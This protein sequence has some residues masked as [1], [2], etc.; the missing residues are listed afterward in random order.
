[1]SQHTYDMYPYGQATNPADTAPLTL[2]ATREEAAAKGWDLDD[3]DWA[4]AGHVAVVTRIEHEEATRPLRM[5]VA[6]NVG[7]VSLSHS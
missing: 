2:R 7:N 6:Q 1:M 3:T 4:D 5:Q